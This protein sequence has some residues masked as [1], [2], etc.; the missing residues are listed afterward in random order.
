MYLFND[1]VVLFE[2]ILFDWGVNFKGVVNIVVFVVLSD[3][4]SIIGM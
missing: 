3:G 2:G 4:I 1:F